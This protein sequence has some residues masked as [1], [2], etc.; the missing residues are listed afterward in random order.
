MNHFKTVW[1]LIGHEWKTSLTS[2]GFWLGV[3]VAPFLLFLIGVGVKY[4]LH[5]PVHEQWLKD[6][7]VNSP[8]FFLDWLESRYNGSPKVLTYGVL[9]LSDTISSEIRNEIERI[10]RFEF[11]T[12]VLDMNSADFQAWRVKFTD[13]SKFETAG[14]L[15]KLENFRTSSISVP[16]EL[17]L[18][19]LLDRG[20]N[21]IPSQFNQ[22]SDFA[23]DFSAWWSRHRDVVADVA[24]A[25][26]TN[27]FQESDADVRLEA[28]LQALL[29]SDEIVGYFVIPKIV[30]GE[31]TELIY[32][33]QNDRPHARVLAMVNWY[34]SVAT[35]VLRKQQSLISGVTPDKLGLSIAH[36]KIRSEEL[37][38]TKSTKSQRN[39]PNY[40]LW[41]LIY[42][43]VLLYSYGMQSLSLTVIEEKSSMLIDQLM[44]NLHPS[45]LLDG[46]VWGNSF[47]YMTM[48]GVW[49]GFFAL[50]S[51]IPWS[52]NLGGFEDMFQFFFRPILV[53]HFLL[54]SL[55]L[56][57]FYGYA[58][59]AIST[60]YDSVKN[61]RRVIG[62]FIIFLVFPFAFSAVSV[63]F[64]SSE[65]VL[66][67]ISLIPPCIP[68]IMVA[69]STTTLPDWPMYLAIVAVM[70]FSIFVVRLLSITPFS[71]GVSGESKRI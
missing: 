60:A 24:P 14:F 15:E 35:N 16:R 54:F 19:P 38:A 13:E 6:K 57:V 62:F 30:S 36:T 71:V 47:I 29:E 2:W 3:G 25:I 7:Q 12:T 65:L 9:D 67:G 18:E 56:Y 21:K 10:D 63:Q 59:T 22:S 53:V 69:R 66:N 45:E 28:E 50:F 33:S 20:S 26:S 39:Y 17:S 49:I 52:Q 11:L 58:L 48:L 37:S 1:I 34:R 32:V 4:V 44:S 70:L 51:E 61:A 5:E 27:F 43:M 64:T 55:L 31:T 41:A 46:K 40:F 42:M 23:R 8:D 68:Y